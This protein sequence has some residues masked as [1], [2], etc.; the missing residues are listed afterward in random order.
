MMIV[1]FSRLGFTNILFAFGNRRG[2]D[3]VLVFTG[4]F[5]LCV[6]FALTGLF[7]MFNRSATVY[8]SI[9]TDMLVVTDNPGNIIII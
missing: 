4:R 3:N 7:D 8:M 9:V 1:R 6:G 5:T 2:F